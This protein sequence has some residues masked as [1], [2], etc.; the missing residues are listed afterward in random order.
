MA[1]GLEHENNCAALAAEA[2]D[3]AERV[4]WM[5]EWLCHGNSLQTA[6]VL[7]NQGALAA[8]VAAH[9]EAGSGYCPHVLLLRGALAAA[10][11][12]LVQLQDLAAACKRCCPDA[13]AALAH[14]LRRHASCL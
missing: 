11:V 6:A 3:C 7:E 5:K 8:A 13:V 2:L 9:A 1:H 4:T 14:S 10:P 12:L